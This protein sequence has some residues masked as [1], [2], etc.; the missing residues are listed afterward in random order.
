MTTENSPIQIEHSY[1]SVCIED[2]AIQAAMQPWVVMECY[3]LSPGKQLAH[4]ETLDIGAQQVVRETQLAAV[5]KVGITPKGFCT[6]SYCTADPSFRFSELGADNNTIFFMP[7]RAEYDI[8]VPAGIQTSYVTFNYEEFLQDA[9][10]LNPQ[11]WDKSPTQLLTICN[12]QQPALMEAITQWLHL[13]QT[14]T[15][16]VSE[17]PYNF[18]DQILQQLLLIATA[19]SSD[20]INLSRAER[21]QAY[22]ICRK[23]REFIENCFATDTVPTIGAICI[24][25]GVSERSLQYAFRTYVNM[26]PLAYLRACRLCRV[27][28]LLRISCSTTTTVTA[29]AMRFGF[30]HLGRF[31]RDY[32]QTFGESPS[33]TLDLTI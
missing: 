26:P 5:Q 29:I 8:Y 19:T 31:A 24:A 10:V 30:F 22:F 25:I 13:T 14:P 1:N 11:Q 3:Q 20:N 12:G 2:A 4:M 27:R 17:Q 6:L 32:K 21:V 9:R 28:S 23:A 18:H 7:E 15:A 16:T 33:A